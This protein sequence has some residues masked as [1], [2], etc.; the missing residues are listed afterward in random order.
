MKFGVMLPHYRQVASTDSIYRVAQEA[1]SMGFH[2]VWV[3]EHI[4]VP[5]GDVDRFGKGY[6]DM[7]TVLGYV[8]AITRRV[9]LGTSIV[10]LPFRP[11]LHVAQ[12]AATVDQLSKGRLILGVGVGSTEA[13]FSPLGASWDERGPITDESIQVLKH[14]WTVDQP[15]FQGRYFQFSAINSYPTP[16]QRPHPPIWIG[17]G[18]RRA[19]R[20]AAEYGDAWH[21]SR[22]SFEHLAESLPRLRR[23]AERAGRDPGGIEVAVRHPLK[24]VDRAPGPMQA[25]VGQVGAPDVWPLVDTPER[26]IEGVG[27]FQELGVSHLVMDTF[28]SI[29][30]LDNETV[31]SVLSTMEGF[32]RHVIPQ[33]P[34]Q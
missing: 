5:D 23:L 32:A 4:A 34:D 3:S 20:R 33:F 30:E 16:V 31:D 25:S 18:S 15:N 22:P 6:Y 21:P 14:V 8:A 24:L 9:L 10:I 19:I 2:S 13:E 29:P 11:P 17:G 27:R 28:Y 1:E 26:V 7:F 12:L